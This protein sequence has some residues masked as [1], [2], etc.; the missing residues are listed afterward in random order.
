[1]ITASDQDP[2]YS[3]PHCDTPV[4]TKKGG[5]C[6]VMYQAGTD[7]RRRYSYALIR[8]RR[9]NDGGWPAPHVGRFTAEKQIRYPL[10]RRLEWALGSGWEGPENIA[11]TGVRIPNRP[12]LSEALY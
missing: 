6:S 2:V 3:R 9:L 11:N 8:P 4:P 10:Y 1:M 12:A 5:G 7:G